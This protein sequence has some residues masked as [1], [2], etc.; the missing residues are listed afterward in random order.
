MICEGSDVRREKSY[1]YVNRPRAQLDYHP[2]SGF[3][4]MIYT[5]ADRGAWLLRDKIISKLDHC[6]LFSANAPMRRSEAPRSRS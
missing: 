2:T 3:A 1:G 6:L 5:L 4:P